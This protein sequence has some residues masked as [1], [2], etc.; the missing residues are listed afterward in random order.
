ML[1]Q[2]LV[3]TIIFSCIICEAQEDIIEP[4][5]PFP[6]YSFSDVFDEQKVINPRFL[7]GKVKTVK[8]TFTQHET[9]ESRLYQENY[10]YELNEH[11][12]VVFYKSDLEEDYLIEESF[13]LLDNSHIKND[14]IINQ[15]VI[16]YT[17]KKGR[18]V[19]MMEDQTTGGFLDSIIYNYKKDKLIEIKGFRSLVAE[20]Y[21]DD[22]GFQEYSLMASE[23]ELLNY[24][25]A[26][27]SKKGLLVAKRMYT[28]FYENVDVYE[29]TYQYDGK[30]IQS[31]QTTKKSYP[32][33]DIDFSTLYKEWNFNEAKLIDESHEVSSGTYKY[34][35]KG[36]IASYQS[37]Q[38][39]YH[40]D[41][42]QEIVEKQDYKYVYAK[43]NTKM[44]V[45]VIRDYKDIIYERGILHQEV[46]YEYLYDKHHNPIEINSY[47][48]KDGKK[49][50][51]K[52]TKLTITYF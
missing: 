40:K 22:V 14:T 15:D 20:E 7:N 41:G 31:Y 48:L 46:I 42:T 32:A 25:Q 11:N 45:F 19:L 26:K 13:S 23:Y 21:V 2:I 4:M 18:M 35:K 47:L 34:D 12:E 37:E 27:Y 52:S 50:L 10:E 17:F 39:A 9:D 30:Q 29:T 43:D 51:D 24:E 28:N 49:H 5:L 8:R 44:E 16:T 1:K 38:I 36:R 33:H 3:F 6:E